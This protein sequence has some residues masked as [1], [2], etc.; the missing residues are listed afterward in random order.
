MQ[1]ST[2]FQDLE[3]NCKLRGLKWFD[4]V[5]RARCC[6]LG[7]CSRPLRVYLLCVGTCRIINWK[8]QGVSDKHFEKMCLL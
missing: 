1:A 3:R 2:I 6:P 4:L 5:A 7:T 8:E